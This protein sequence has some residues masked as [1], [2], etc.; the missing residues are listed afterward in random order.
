MGNLSQF[1][2]LVPGIFGE[3]IFK[4]FLKLIAHED[5][6]ELYHL[7]DKLFGLLQLQVDSIVFD[8]VA[9]FLGS[10]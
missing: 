10:A 4:V 1:L 2:D 3:V 5:E 7:S 8:P 9:V 6:D